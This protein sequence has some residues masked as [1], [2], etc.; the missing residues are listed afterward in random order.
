MNEPYNWFRKSSTRTPT[1]LE[2]FNTGFL[3]KGKVTN[4]TCILLESDCRYD[5]KTG[6]GDCRVCNFAFAH[7]MGRSGSWKDRS[8]T[9]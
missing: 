7:M 3:D 1:D 6:T 5:P 8:E 4:Y 9:K 2:A